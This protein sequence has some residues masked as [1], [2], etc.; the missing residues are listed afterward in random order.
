MAKDIKQ[1]GTYD[2]RKTPGRQAKGNPLHPKKT[3][4]QI[5][6]S[7]KNNNKHGKK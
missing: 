3:K 5:E 2:G 4:S 6:A 1:D 7:L